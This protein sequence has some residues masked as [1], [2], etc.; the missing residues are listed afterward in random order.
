V[1]ESFWKKL[2]TC[3]FD[4]LLMMMMMMMMMMYILSYIVKRIFKT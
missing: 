4:R 3:R 2:W 1:E